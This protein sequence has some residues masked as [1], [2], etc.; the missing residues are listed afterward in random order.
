MVITSAIKIVQH[1]NG[2]FGYEYD[3]SKGVP[4]DHGLI[5]SVRDEV[6]AMVCQ[7]TDLIWM[8]SVLVWPMFQSGYEMW[9]KFDTHGLVIKI[10]DN[11]NANNI[12]EI[13]DY[14]EPNFTA[15]NKVKD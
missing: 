1:L 4:K 11:R 13:I 14:E 12:V 3:E 2:I 8:L 9:Q 15:D 6:M 7:L 10:G 5:W